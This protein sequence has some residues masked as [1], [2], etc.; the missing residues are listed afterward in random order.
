MTDK[1]KADRKARPSATDAPAPAGQKDDTQLSDAALDKVVGGADFSYS[2][3]GIQ[4]KV[5]TN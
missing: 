3:S 5:P 1:S 4:K 2:K